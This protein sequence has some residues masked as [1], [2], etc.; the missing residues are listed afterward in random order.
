[1][2]ACVK[3]YAANNQE[4]NRSTVSAEMDERTLREI[5]LPAFKASVVEANVHSVMT[6]YN[7]FRGVYCAENKHLVEDILRKEWGFDGIV[8]S[9]WAGTHST[10]NSAL[11]GIDV[12]MGTF[13]QEPYLGKPLIDSVKRGF[14]SVKIIDAK[15]RNVLKVL[16]YAM[17]KDK[18]PKSAELST[19]EHHQTAYN[20]AVQSVVLLKNQKDILPLAVSK[21]KNIAVI[22]DNATHKQAFGG[23]GAG[24]KAR[25][26]I[27]PLDGI[28]AKFGKSINISFAQGY[29]P[30][31]ITVPNQRY[32]KV[33][34]YTVNDTLLKEAVNVAKNADVVI[35]FAGTNRDVESEA[36]DRVDMKLPFGQDQLLKAIAA[37]NSRI[38]VVVVAA[39][40]V[41]LG[42][43]NQVAPAIV[44]SWFNGSEGGNAI[45]DVLTGTVNP[46][47]KLPL[48]FPSG[49]MILLLMR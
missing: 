36:S 43:C 25:Y 19:P 46:S 30:E 2:I 11:Y 20:I 32:G 14:V 48:Q 44:W 16:L 42:T 34:T 10:V 18:E 23:F 26:E 47:G 1:V 7:K 8:V 38:V 5:Y 17:R 22:G 6:A 28:K 21:L 12:E 49:L 29:R 4:T 15:A 27:S 33:P 37:A 45:A 39:A 41:D 31:Y 35:F 24:V 13:R 40:P 3:H 9:D